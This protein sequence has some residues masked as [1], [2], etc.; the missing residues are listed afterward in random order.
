MK[1]KKVIG[2]VLIVVG[3]CIPL[4]AFTQICIND[5]HSENQYSEYRR[6]YME[7]N[8]KDNIS[9]ESKEDSITREERLK[10]EIDEYEARL[11]QGDGI[12][13]PFVA[14]N[15]K[16]VYGIKGIDPDAVFGY[17][18]V[19][20]I[21]VKKP[22]WLDATYKHLDKGVAHVYGTSLPTGGKGKR[23]VIAGHRGWYRD[24]MLLNLGKVKNGDKVYIDR[25][26]KVLTYVVTGRE[27]ITPSEWQ[28]LRP[29]SG[30]DMLTLLSCEPIIPPSPYRLLINCERVVDNV[31]EKQLNFNQIDKKM[32]NEKNIPSQTSYVFYIITLVG[33]ILL[34]YRIYRLVL[35]IRKK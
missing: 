12:V 4:Q 21:D 19:P 22:I 31:D 32:A 27:I 24:I 6:Q 30:K 17:L 10:D 26:G 8:K 9:K 1:F 2:H 25:N 13:D 7:A 11:S 20:S 29:I 15:Y 34:L 18:I 28:K 5:M 23:A 14:D 16:S 33:W 3:I 35:E